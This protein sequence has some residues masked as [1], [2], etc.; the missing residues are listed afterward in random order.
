MN[1]VTYLMFD[2][3]QCE[4]AFRF[5]ER[6]LGGKLEMLVRYGDMPE[7]A[8]MDEA[9]RKK[10]AHVR[11]VMDGS[12]LMGSDAGD[13]SQ[14]WEGYKGFFVCINTH[15][16]DQAEK[17][18]NALSEQARNIM[19]PLAKTSWSEK[20][21]QLMDRYGVEWMVNCEMKA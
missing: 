3:S 13:P 20:Y 18:F 14:T 7:C 4:E 17:V 8:G 15:D 2:N 19:M 10:I 12:M 6:C 9:T 5:Y 1:V 11:L 16:P 21:G